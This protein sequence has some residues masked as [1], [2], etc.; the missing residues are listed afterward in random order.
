MSRY[1][2]RI[3]RWSF[4]RRR[5]VTAVW[6]LVLVGMVLL[7]VL[8]GGKTVNDFSIPGTPSTQGLDLLK[9]RTPSASGGQT[10]VVFAP[11]NSAKL[12][13]PQIKTT[14]E[15]TMRQ[16]QSGPQV[17]S[18]T[19]PYQAQAIAPTGSVGYGQ[20][21][22]D[23]DIAGIEE[24]SLTALDT[25]AQSA[26]DAG[27]QVEFG[28]QVYPGFDAAPSELPEIVGVGIAFIVLL[29]MFGALIAAGLPI[30]TAVVGVVVSL[31]GIMALASVMNVQSATNSLAIMLSLA[32]GID[33][34]LFILTRHR[35]TLLEGEEVEE[36]V[37]RA[38]GTSGG[39]VVF[40][41]LTVMIA[42]CGL[43]VVGIPFLTIMGLTAAA[44]VFVAVL[45][46]LTLLPAL[47]GFAGH[48]VT[49]FVRSPVPGREPE[50]IARKTVEEPHRTMGAMWARFVI[51]WRVPLLVAGLLLL[52][53]MAIPALSMK[54]GLPTGESKADSDTSHKAYELI[55]EGFGPGANG[56]L[57]IVVDT[58]KSTDPR[59]VDQM[60][61]LVKGEQDVATASI[62]A[63]PTNN[64]AIISAIPR[65]APNDSSTT[66]LV[67]SIREQA[68]EL[69]E[70]NGTEVY[71]VGQTATNIDTTDKLASALP[72]FLIV[73]VGL[74]IVLL[75]I[76]FRTV[77]V[78]VK[79]IIGFLLS[80]AAAFGAQVAVFQW[81]WLS[82]LFGVTASDTLSF[83]PIIMLAIIFGLSN[84]YEIFLVARI[85]EH[86]E[87]SGDGLVAVERGL[88]ASVRVVSAAALIMIGVFLSFVFTSDPI[89]KAIG[90]SLA[91]GVL[92]DAFVVRLMLVPAVMAIVKDK[93]WY[94]P[95][96]FGRVVPDLDIEGEKLE[97]ELARR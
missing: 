43:S 69:G 58:A 30:L 82:S 91:V 17:V 45:L 25:A 24:S 62:A 22:F 14:I 92:V 31:M 19:D 60:L 38:V 55:V 42:L 67:K 4:R 87:R 32:C 63:P 46:P 27:I 15:Q 76:A 8:S 89:V 78:P 39:A 5:L 16:M 66:D 48:K 96:W 13:D 36:S 90:F 20:V 54:L 95:K 65:S 3:A 81:G 33:Y 37:A 6:G 64:T 52:L 9:E 29:V 41:G 71:V 1:L 94:H 51:R 86:L 57:N 23:S 12:T 35:A 40:A 75:T 26:R 70:R 68:A 83:L 59:A 84:D 7:G 88:G 49:K 18:A 2:Y 80:I 97:R 56:P 50:Q 77:L 61:E 79:S 73:V 72:I 10:Q 85:K 11:Q 44:A 21:Q 34:A 28:G 53:I 74:A 47:L 93:L